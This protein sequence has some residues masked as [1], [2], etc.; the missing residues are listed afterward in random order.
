MRAGGHARRAQG[1]HSW[2]K[3]PAGNNNAG[4]V[5]ETKGAGDP[6]HGACRV[7]A[8]KT[9]A[10]SGSGTSPTAQRSLPRRAGPPWPR[11][12]ALPVSRPA[13]PALPGGLPGRRSPGAGEAGGHGPRRALGA[14]GTHGPQ[15]GPDARAPPAP[16]G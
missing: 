8:S 14:G 3:G 9:R 4:A 5:W 1:K 15:R 12:G 2:R 11:L 6:A 10:L 16:H 7:R 13:L